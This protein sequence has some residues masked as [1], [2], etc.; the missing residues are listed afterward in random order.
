MNTPLERALEAD[1]APSSGWP[2]QP[3]CHVIPEGEDEAGRVVTPAGELRFVNLR[4]D[5]VMMAGQHGHKLAQAVRAGVVP[6][7]DAYL[8]KLLQRSPAWR[9]AR[10]L[11][12]GAYRVAAKQMRARYPSW[13]RESA[14]ELAARSGV[15]EAQVL[16]AYLMP[17]TFLW[18]VGTYHKTLGTARDP[19]LGM[20]PTAGCTSVITRTSSG[21]MHGRN[22]DYFGIDRWEP[23]AAVIFHHPDQG[24]RY[25]S[26]TTAGLLGAGVTAMNA[27]GL[28]LAVHQHFIDRFDLGGVPIGVAA[29]EVM[30]QAHTIEEAIAILRRH[31]PICGWA[32]LMTE[33]DTGRAAILELAPGR[34]ALSWLDADAPGMGYANT[35]TSAM[36]RDVAVDYYPHYRRSSHA[37][38]KRAHA[39]AMARPQTPLEVATALADCT[40]PDTDQ[41]RLIGHTVMATNTISS[42]VFE[43]AQRRIWVAAGVSP[44]S[45]GWFV[46]FALSTPDRPHEGGPDLGV[47]PFCVAPD[48]P[49]TRQG[50]AFSLYRQAHKRYLDVEGDDALLITLEH[51]LALAPEES[52]LHMMTG[53]FALRAGRSA[54]AEGALRRALELEPHAPRRAEIAL[55]LAM[56][57]DV[58]GRRLEARHLYKR[59]SADADAD[60]QVRALAN[61]RRRARASQQH[62]KHLAAEFTYG[63]VTL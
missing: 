32:Y 8:Y 21:V 52:T 10:T 57:I 4:G 38:H 19:G 62:V 13:M 60:P 43:P 56:A 20:A 17:E 29:D 18:L 23:Q 12:W 25:V 59:L 61:A 3:L 9:L 6:C 27:A 31:P 39:A 34:E 22:L 53:L 30:R 28:T 49:Q 55:L 24:L 51:A 14:R 35:Y 16:N 46:P 47:A 42:V 44:T 37:R 15:S 40:D 54:R 58:Q 11:S 33:G 50:R 48:W 63:G 7:F 41:A 2:S 1:T 26:A 5:Q 36:M 45:R